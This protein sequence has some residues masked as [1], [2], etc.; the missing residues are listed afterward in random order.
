[1]NNGTKQASRKQVTARCAAALA[2]L[3][4][5]P[6]AR[7]VRWETRAKYAKLYATLERHEQLAIEGLLGPDGQDL[8]AD[9]S[10]GFL[11]AVKASCSAPVLLAVQDCYNYW[12]QGL[13]S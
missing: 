12:R 5:A 11:A 8:F 1:M 13:A 3:E 4:T 6:E 10:R 7:E 9:V 2:T